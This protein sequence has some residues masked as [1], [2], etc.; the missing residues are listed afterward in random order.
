MIK[1]IVTSSILI[2]VIITLRHLLKGKI[3]LRLQY[4][5]WGLVLLRLLIPFSI[6]SSGFSVMN[7]VQKVP[8][9]Q[10]AESISNV[11][12]IEH[13]TDGSVE[14]YYPSDFMGDFPTVVAESKTAEEYARMEKVLSFRKAFIPIWLCGAAI[15][16]IVFA[17]SNR[18]FSSRLRR[19]RK[20]LEVK[21]SA[22]PVYI[23]NETDTP[24]LFGLFSPEIYVTS[25]AAGDATILWHTV[26]HE[27]THFRHGDNF[28]SVLRVICLALHW[29]NPL[30]W[31]AAFLSRNDV[32]LAC[33]E[34]TILRIGEAQ[35]A[36]YGRT[37]IAMTCQKRTAFLIAATI[38]TGSKSS[39]KERITRIAKKPK[40]LIPAVIA[41]LLVAFVVVGCTFTGA[42]TENAKIISLTADESEAYNKA[43][44]PLLYDEQ[45]NAISVNP[46]SQFLSSYYDRPEDIN[47]AE[48]LRYFPS[49]GTVTDK[50]EFEALKDSENWPFGANMT[51]DG[52]PVIIHKFS[53]D[54]VNRA[55]K[56]Y[57]GITLEDLSGAGMDKLIYLKNYHA[58]Y[59]FTSFTSDAGFGSFTCVSGERQG[60]LVRLFGETA[61]L[62]LKIQGDGF[63]IVSHQLTG[64][65]TGANTATDRI[66]IVA[67]GVDVPDM[68]LAAAK[69]QAADDFSVYS[70]NHPDY[71]YED[72]QIDTLEKVY[73]YNDLDGL[74]LD[75]YK[76][77]DEF[78]SD[79]P[80]N[81]M[82][83]GGM[84]MTDDGWVWHCYFNYLIV[85]ADEGR[86]LFTLV[87]IDASP[88]FGAFTADL[89]ARLEDY[90]SDLQT[91][92]E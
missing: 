36:E 89:E 76:M 92:D 21:G 91:P 40:L 44:E 53:A 56:K 59:N 45:G 84:S 10:D 69:V 18:R 29:Y 72:W 17:A 90:E 57:M 52:M 35:R 43:F 63:W 65:V 34:A 16:F 32:E 82:L 80:K 60:D 5:L 71:E 79:A 4:A 3:S 68:V 41:V 31:W 48:L 58:Y 22:L 67:D 50:T 70:T 85:D 46:I 19:T 83:P 2:A 14:G 75:V 64:E 37:L 61:T 73:T 33:D 20:P 9:V 24:C 6:G 27:T 23:S 28:W 87:E 12:R 26:E 25:E 7:L 62:T 11:D 66:G 81:V 8:V 30:V 39:I 78:L 74:T 47:L 86:Y 1:W 13:M 77:T 55:L 38:M 88:G 42:K 49:D 51:L 54:T 15:L